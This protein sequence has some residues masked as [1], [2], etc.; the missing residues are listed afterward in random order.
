MQALHDISLA[1]NDGA[2]VA[3]I[4]VEKSSLFSMLLLIKIVIQLP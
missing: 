3:T 2:M 4:A 1:N